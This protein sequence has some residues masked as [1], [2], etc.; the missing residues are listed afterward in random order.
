ME[1]SETGPWP[2]GIRS[3]SYQTTPSRLYRLTWHWVKCINHQRRRALACLLASLFRPSALR[4]CL[5][6][7]RGSRITRSTAS[8]TAGVDSTTNEPTYN[9][10]WQTI[11]V[12][13][14]LSP[15]L[16]ARGYIRSATHNRRV[17]CRTR[18]CR[19]AFGSNCCWPAQGRGLQSFSRAT[20]CSNGSRRLD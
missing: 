12:G 2:T 14:A 3:P 7:H 5:V 18:S 6:R 13:S 4:A 17:E 16:V 10:G 20:L 1:T 15:K 8:T 11:S 19:F 9:A